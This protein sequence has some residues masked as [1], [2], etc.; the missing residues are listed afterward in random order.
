MS[1]SKSWGK[2]ANYSA[3]ALLPLLF[4]NY[5]NKTLQIVNLS[6]NQIGMRGGH[7]FGEVLERNRCLTDLDLSNNLL[8]GALFY[9]LT[10]TDD[11]LQFMS[12][13]FSA[14]LD[15]LSQRCKCNS[16]V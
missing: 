10:L 2:C 12:F 13:P 7:T 8:R 16:I 5:R 1:L 9:H 4:V 3:C 6:N 14:V 11:F 15:F